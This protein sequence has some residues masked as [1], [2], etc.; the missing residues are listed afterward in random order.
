VQT[1][2]KETV[3]IGY[4]ESSHA[5]GQRVS[6]GQSLDCGGHRSTECDRPL[7]KRVVHSASR[8]LFVPFRK[9]LGGDQSPI[10]GSGKLS[11]EFAADSGRMTD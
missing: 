8:G 9:T 7:K 10:E 4:E 3:V 5:S 11:L 2:P 6:I 1:L